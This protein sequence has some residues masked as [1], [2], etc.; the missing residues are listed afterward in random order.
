VNKKS[1]VAKPYQGF[2]C[3]ILTWCPFLKSILPLQPQ[4]Q[5]L[6]IKYFV[7]LSIQTTQITLPD[8]RRTTRID[9]TIL[10]E[11]SGRAGETVQLQV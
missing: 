4:R 1:D 5:N 11:K 2:S 9:R 8:G 3:K 6:K 7:A 10:I